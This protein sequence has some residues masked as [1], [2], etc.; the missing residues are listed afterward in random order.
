[1]IVSLIVYGPLAMNTIIL[2]YY[3]INFEPGKFIYWLG[4]EILNV[5]VIMM[6]G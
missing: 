4:A 6:K 3:L 5:G 1:M 2:L